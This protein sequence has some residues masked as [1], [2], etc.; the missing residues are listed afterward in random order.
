M[1]ILL[2][3]ANPFNSSWVPISL[4]YIAAF[5][6]SRGHTTRVVTIGQDSAFSLSSLISYI[7]DF[8]PRLVGLSAY[9]R[10]MLP[11]IGLAR[12]VK[13]A[14]PEA[15]VAIGGPQATF[16]PPEALA[17][18][19]EVDYIC[20]KEGELT[21]L[22]IARAI[23][24]GRPL[25]G[26]AGA[27]YRSRGAVVEGAS[28]EGPKDLDEYPS[29]Y[30]ADVFDYAQV[31]EAI[32]LTS[33]GCSY[34]CLF[35]YTPHAFG[36]KIRFHSL[37][38]VMEEVRWL[39]RRGVKRL[40]FAD[41]TISFQGA[42][43]RELLERIIREDLGL[44]IWLETRVDLVTGELTQQMRAAGV[45]TI[46]F[47]LESASERVLGALSKNI[48]AD[49]ARRAI[50]LAQAAGLEVELFTMFG[51]PGEGMEEAMETLEFVK[52]NGVAIKGNS[53][54]QQMQLYFGTDITRNHA[55]YGIR[56]LEEAR[57]AYIS[58]GN[59]YETERLSLEDMRRIKEAWR[60]SSLDRGARVVS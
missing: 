1:N 15:W 48:S 20:R 18:L 49:Q 26:V 59:Q 22:S 47:G 41:P 30:L 23:E 11:V 28:V 3:E 46:A 31:K 58:I 8:K 57:P 45:K 56:P 43:L 40:W 9:Q 16:M 5:L 50:G 19:P 6:N 13:A 60:A 38:R 55:R 33:R 21:L 14:C 27:C 12:L 37:E 54:S 25:E 29:P 2:I 44:E 52:S 32:L 24:A 51:L 4:G 42:R 53:N 35:C 10:T 17:E 39:A 7:Q 36:H 34:R